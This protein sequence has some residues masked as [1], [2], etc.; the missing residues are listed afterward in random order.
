MKILTNF[1][2]FTLLTLAHLSGTV[3]EAPNLDV[4]Q[5]ALNELPED[6]LVVFDVDCT[7][8]IPKDQ[9]LAP[10][11]EG[12]LKNY[13]REKIN[14]ALFIYSYYKS[15]MVVNII[16]YLYDSKLCEYVRLSFLD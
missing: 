9:A 11:G 6:S 13:F 16:Y 15:Y 12:Y 3:T 8:I 4:I 2:L 5:K 14:V 1:F 10:C 7:I